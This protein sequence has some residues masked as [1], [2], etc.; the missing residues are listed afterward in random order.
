MP[1][2]PR[3]TSRK[4]WLEAALTK[5]EAAQAGNF[6]QGQAMTFNGRSVQRYS[7]EELERLRVRYDAELV[8][9]ERID[10][11]TYT[12]TVRVIG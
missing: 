12:T 5:I 10:S 1:L 4:A 7:P 2:T 3:Q 11:G 8:K 6:D 9:L